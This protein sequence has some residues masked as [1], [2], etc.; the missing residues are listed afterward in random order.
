MNPALKQ[1]KNR[2]RSLWR[3]GKLPALSNRELLAEAGRFHKPR[4]IRRKP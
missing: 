1:I 4:N 2:T 3:D